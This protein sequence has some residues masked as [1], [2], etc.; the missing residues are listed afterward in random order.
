MCLYPKLFLCTKCLRNSAHSIL[1]RLWSLCDTYLTACC[2]LNPNNRAHTREVRNCDFRCS[3]HFRLIAA[4]C[5]QSTSPCLPV[6]DCTHQ[7]RNRALHSIV[8]WVVFA[9]LHSCVLAVHRDNQ[10]AHHT[11]DAIHRHTTRVQQ[12]ACFNPCT[13]P[14]AY[15]WTFMSQYKQDTFPGPINHVGFRKPLVNYCAL[16][17][18][19]MH[20]NSV[21][22]P[23]ARKFATRSNLHTASSPAHTANCLHAHFKIRFPASCKALDMGSLCASHTLGNACTLY[24]CNLCMH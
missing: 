9:T 8:T 12:L 21:G 22:G 1:C 7:S 17:F 3:P 23:T 11:H 15:V 10:A 13:E 6:A 14:I 18:R 19:C 4:V 2:N 16:P 20:Y 24:A 5:I